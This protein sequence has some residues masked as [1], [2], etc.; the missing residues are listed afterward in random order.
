MSLT[1]N[2]Q[3]IDEA[4]IEQEFSNIKSSFEQL[5][6]F[7]GCCE[8][9]DEF[10]GYAE[11]NIIARVLLTQEAERRVEPIPGP[12]LDEAVEQLKQ[13]HGGEQQFYVAFG[14]GPE[15]EEAVRRDVELNLRVNQLIQELCDDISDPDDATLT[16]F[17]EDHLDN[18]KTE[19]RLRASHI[20]RSPTRGEDRAEAYQQMRQARKRLLDGEDFNTVAEELSDKVREYREASEEE[21]EKAGDP[22]DLGYIKRGELMEEFDLIAFSMHVDEISPVFGTSFGLHLVKV[23]EYDPATPRP[24]D[25]I[26]DQVREDYLQE[27]R[28]ERVKQFVDQLKTKADIQRDHDSD[29]DDE[30]EQDAAAEHTS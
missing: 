3:A 11:D 16:R 14:V 28:G 20:L 1:I 29:G 8:R 2:G 15:Q 30:A 24:L 7:A 13:D 19:E 22:I 18:Y 6:P 21:R 5:N 17:Y 26:R 10:R 9:D 23:T 4:L 25:D 27:K 12:Q